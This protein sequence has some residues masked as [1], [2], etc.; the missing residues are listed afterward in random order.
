M[1]GPVD[2]SAYIDR[3]L[4]SVVQGES[5]EQAMRR[6]IRWLS[7]PYGDNLPIFHGVDNDALRQTYIEALAEDDGDQGFAYAAE[8]AMSRPDPHGEFGTPPGTGAY[9][10]HDELMRDPYGF[11]TGPEPRAGWFQRRRNLRTVKKTIRRHR[12]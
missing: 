11:G 10:M 9:A 1:P 5:R 3:L 4:T 7:L 12:G 6:L 2:E 8:V